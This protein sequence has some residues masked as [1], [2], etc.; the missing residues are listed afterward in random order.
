MFQGRT[1]TKH[2]GRAAAVLSADHHNFFNPKSFWKLREVYKGTAAGKRPHKPW[3]KPH[4]GST[5]DQ[6]KGKE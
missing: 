6:Q 3:Q 1:N 5:A 2:C 4:K